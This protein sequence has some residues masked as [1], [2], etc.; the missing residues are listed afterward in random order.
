MED[1]NEIIKTIFIDSLCFNDML[2]RFEK[3]QS[4]FVDEWILM[5]DYLMAK[6]SI[7]DDIIILNDNFLIW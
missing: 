5:M 4:E 6:I 3:F 7:M 1:S 2:C